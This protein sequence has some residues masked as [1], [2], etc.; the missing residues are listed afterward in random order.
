MFLALF[1]LGVE[2]SKGAPGQVAVKSFLMASQT[3]P[4]ELTWTVFVTS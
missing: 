2:R 3:L 4:G 1:P